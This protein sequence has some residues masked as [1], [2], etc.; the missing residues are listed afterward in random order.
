MDSTLIFTEHGSSLLEI[1]SQLEAYLLQS[2]IRV[3][4]I[5]SVLQVHTQLLDWCLTGHSISSTVRK[6]SVKLDQ[7]WFSAARSCD[8]PNLVSTDFVICGSKHSLQQSC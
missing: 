1:T 4:H 6:L 3:S 7:Y 2:F 8:V 5:K